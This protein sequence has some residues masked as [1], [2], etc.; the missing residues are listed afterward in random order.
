VSEPAFTEQVRD[1]LPVE[2]AR[3]VVPEDLSNLAAVDTGVLVVHASWSGSSI[4]CLNCWGRVVAN[5]AHRDPWLMI[6]D[7]D[8]VAPTWATDTLG[9][10]LTGNGEAFWIRRGTIEH[11][12]AGYGLACDDLV[13]PT[14]AL[15][16]RMR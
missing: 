1:R 10:S 12:M 6:V 5:I 16:G 3:I 9:Q 15:L 7:A 4:A 8:L 11:R 14:R 2:H 13:A